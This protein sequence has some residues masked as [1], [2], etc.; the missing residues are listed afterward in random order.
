[1]FYY[2]PR[3]LDYEITP[4]HPLKPERLRR[5]IELMQR[6][7][8]EMTDPGLATESDVLRVH[9]PEY[10]E[11]VRL[12]DPNEQGEKVTSEGLD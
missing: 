2:H 10:L 5:A 9:S 11:A 4:T 3:M 6:L 12:L 7:G 8:I 1:M